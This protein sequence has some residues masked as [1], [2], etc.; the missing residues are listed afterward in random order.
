MALPCGF[1]FFR[2]GG[3]YLIASV[4]LFPLTTTPQMRGRKR[5]SSI[6]DKLSGGMDGAEGG[7]GGGG[8]GGEGSGKGGVGRVNKGAARQFNA[9]DYM[10]GSD[11]SSN[12][13]LE[14]EDVDNVVE[15]SGSGLGFDRVG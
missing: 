11:V 10:I 5:V 12:A 1:R 8:R 4:F 15:M 7:G 3:C 13:S 14:D 2:L 6:I 9:A